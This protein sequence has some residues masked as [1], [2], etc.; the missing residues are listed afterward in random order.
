MR[1]LRMLSLAVFPVLAMFSIAGANRTDG[2]CFNQRYLLELLPFLS[3]ALVLSLE[4]LPFRWQA[5]FLGGAGSFVPLVLWEPLPAQHASLFMAAPLAV[6]AALVGVWLLRKRLP[7]S[8]PLGALL[9]VSLGWALAVHLTDDVTKS[10]DMRKRNL[11]I[12]ELLGRLIP[13]H[14]AVFAWYG[15][16]DPLGLLQMDRDVVIVDPHAD[17][18]KDAGVL[19]KA[20]LTRKRRLFVVVPGTPREVLADVL[21][22]GLS[23][24]VTTNVRGKPTLIE[25]K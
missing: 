17:N 11:D 22:Q 16:K 4:Q 24:V 23:R 9:G 12:A 6:A 3:V 7:V 18:G 2:F 8:F 10:R 13:D 20:L 21:R 14:S 25:V 1:E 19:A 15:N 5:V